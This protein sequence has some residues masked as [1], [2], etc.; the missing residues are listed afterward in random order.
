MMDTQ[1]KQE[2]HLH[3]IMAF[4]GGF[5][6]LYTIV[7]RCDLFGSAQTSNLIFLIKSIIGGN[8]CDILL[9]LGAFVLYCLGILLTVWLP[10]H[11]DVSLPLLSI[12]I[13]SIAALILGFLPRE[14]NP[15]LALYPVF[16]AMAFQWC[17]FRGIEG[18]ISATTFSTNNLRQFLTACYDYLTTKQPEKRIR[19]QFYGCTLAAFHIGV[20]GS[21]LAYR[22]CDIRSIWFVC[23][24]ASAALWRLV[25]NTRLL[26]VS[27]PLKTV[28]HP[29]AAHRP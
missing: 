1:T 21:Y 17:C 20:A 26:P 18:C 6:G 7:T 25:L 19:L 27:L 16:F 10:K 3:Y 11:S 4:I 14:T 12:V 9:R 29:N 28:I 8:L 15:I 5:F 22:F 23:V 24:P 13:D 2:A